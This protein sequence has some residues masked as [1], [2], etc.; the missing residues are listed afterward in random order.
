MPEPFASRNHGALLPLAEVPSVLLCSRGGSK[1]LNISPRTLFSL[2]APRGPIPAVRIG[3]TLRYH[4][5]DLLAFIEDS[6]TSPRDTN[7]YQAR[8]CAAPQK[9]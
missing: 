3:R 6:K 4:V 1:F 5:R 2:T 8:H 7:N 9:R